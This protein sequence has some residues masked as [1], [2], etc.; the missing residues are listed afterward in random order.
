[1]L[2]V[3]GV[4]ALGLSVSWGGVGLSLVVLPLVGGPGVSL[5]V[6]GG[7][8]VVAFVSG[9][10]DA[11]SWEVLWVVVAVD[12]EGTR[13]SRGMGDGVCWAVYSSCGLEL[14]GI[15]MRLS[16]SSFQRSWRGGTLWGEV[17]LS[18]DESSSGGYWD[19]GI[20]PGKSGGRFVWRNWTGVED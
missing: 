19:R 2:Y 4:A 5:S 20:N 17:V 11:S 8:L 14:S 10:G 6:V 3:V 1:M 9:I 7:I 12:W 15:E 13:I 18:F 16:S